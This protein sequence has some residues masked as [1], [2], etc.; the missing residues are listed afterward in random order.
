MATKQLSHHPEL[1]DA[2]AEEPFDEERWIVLEDW[3]LE[4]EDPRADLVILEK[5]GA[6][7]KRRLRGLARRL[8]GTKHAT[9][10][11]KVYQCD[12]RAGFLRECQYTGGPDPLSSFL[13][14]PASSL[15]R[16]F[17]LTASPSDIDHAV[18]T[19]VNKAC[20]RSLRRLTLSSWN[21][22]GS[23]HR[24]ACAGLENMVQLRHLI[25]RSVMLAAAPALPRLHAL[26]LAPMRTGVVA[27]ADQI[28]QIAWPSIT[29]LSYEAPNML[30]DGI[31]LRPLLALVDETMFPKL[32]RLTVTGLAAA[33]LELATQ[34]LGDACAKRG[35]A[36]V[37]AP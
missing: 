21:H 20:V 12:W 1:E 27:L 35:V 30:G 9:I 8:L 15:L 31:G 33:E 2:L 6:D 18:G 4:C 3:L 19:F 36:L 5:R 28:S 37:I 22:D 11:Q 34:A 14:A 32:E 16:A 17:M 10:V 7:T 26:T 24:I 29:D 23:D 13:E 25:L